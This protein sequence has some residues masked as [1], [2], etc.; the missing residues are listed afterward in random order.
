MKR[1]SLVALR[2]A[3]G[4]PLPPSL[5]LDVF[6]RAL[7]RRR[8]RAVRGDQRRPHAAHRRRERR[9]ARCRRHAGQLVSAA[10]ALSP[11]LVLR[12]RDPGAEAAALEAWRPGQRVHAARRA[13]RRPMRCSPRSAAAC[14]SSAA[15]RGLSRGFPAARTIC[16]YAARSALAPTP[17]RRSLFARARPHAPVR[18]A[19][20]SRR[21]ARRLP[22]ALARGRRA[23]LATL[24][25][26][27]CA[28]FGE[29]DALPR[30]GLARR[31]G[32]DFVGVLDRVRGA[33]FPNRALPFVPPP[34]YAGKLDL[35][36][37]VAR[38][39]CARV[40][41]QPARA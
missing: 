41:G 31:F 38:R 13:S 40:R 27:A 2:H 35:P 17:P 7:A 8:R 24:A 36:A 37:P 1:H 20:A 21:R 15:W 33:S 22:L 28:T 18:D 9:R 12:E 34:R 4:L 39:R 14:G 30:D 32:A 26:P 19:R 16:G 6:A 29:A 3:L 25:P 10:L 11:D 5:P 23:R